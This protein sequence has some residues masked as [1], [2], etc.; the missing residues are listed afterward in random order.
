MAEFVPGVEILT[1]AELAAR[2]Q[3]STR[4]V[5]R[6]ARRMG[7]PKVGGMYAVDGTI[8]ASLCLAGAKLALT[9]APSRRAKRV[10]T[11]PSR[12]DRVEGWARGGASPG[13]TTSAD[14]KKTESESGQVFDFKGNDGGGAAFAL[15]RVE[16]VA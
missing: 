12:A 3:R 11:N 9:N 10:P 14:I 1:V 13:P 16:E 5:R 15:V 4:T 6:V 8:L 2:L 7:W